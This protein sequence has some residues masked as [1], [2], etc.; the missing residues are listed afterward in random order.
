MHLNLLTIKTIRNYLRMKTILFLLAFL[1]AFFN[2]SQVQIV[3]RDSDIDYAS[4]TV[5][6][7]VSQTNKEYSDFGFVSIYLDVTNN[8]SETKTLKITRKK[9]NVPAQWHDLLCWGI[10]CYDISSDDEASTPENEAVSS[11][12]GST[13]ELKLEINPNDV[14]GSGQFRYY[15]VDVSNNNEKLDSVDV[16]FNFGLASIKEVRKDI[17]FTV[18]PNPSTDFVKINIA[19]N[20]TEMDVKIVDVLGNTILVDTMN[21]SKTINVS[22]FKNGIYFISISTKD[23]KVISRKMIVRH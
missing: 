2:F 7:N 18:T 11:V 20:S 13:Y 12:D 15:I 8:S 10:G 23:K 21:D 14:V 16:V 1:T 3:E 19:N 9:I 5:V 17:Q 6:V 4:D 22:Q